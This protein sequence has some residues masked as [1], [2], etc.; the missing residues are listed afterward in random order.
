MLHR[1][2]A[3]CFLIRKLLLWL[4]NTVAQAANALDA[5]F[6]LIA[7]LQEFWGVKAN[8]HTLRGSGGNDVTGEQLHALRQGLDEG[9]DIKDQVL[10]VGVLAQLAIDP[11]LYVQILMVDFI[12]RHNDRAHGAKAVQGFAEEPLL[13]LF[14]AIAGGDVIDDGVTKDVVHGLLLAD[15]ASGLA[16]DNSQLGLI[17]HL[18]GGLLMCRDEGI[19]ADDSIDCLGKNHRKIRA[20]LAGIGAAVKA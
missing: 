18:L 20:V 13:V 4:S 10:G 1:K 6:D 14:L 8:A 3:I 12:G 15:A 9:R 7:G 17:V 16:D 19:G 11:A 2:K 5:D